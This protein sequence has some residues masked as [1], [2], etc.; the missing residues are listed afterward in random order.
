[1][2]TTFEAADQLALGAQLLVSLLVL[3]TI[4]DIAQQKEDASTDKQALLDAISKIATQ[5]AD[6]IDKVVK[7]CE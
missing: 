3:R 5:N 7:A 6:V 1:M 2:K 4:A